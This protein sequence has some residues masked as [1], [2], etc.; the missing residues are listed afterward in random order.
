MP[1]RSAFRNLSRPALLLFLSVYSLMVSAG[2]R[3]PGK[4]S[5]VVIFDRW[6]TCFLLSGPYITYV[7]NEVKEGLRAYRNQAIQI[8]ASDVMQP[9]NP[10][11]ALIRK[12]RIIGPALE[13]S[14]EPAVE[15]IHISIENDFDRDH[16]TAFLITIENL[17]NVPVQIDSTTIGPALLGPKD[18]SPFNPSDGKSMAWITRCD[19]SASPNWSRT[20][21]VNHRTVSAGYS[22]DPNDNE[23]IRFTL[24]PGES[25][26]IHIN[27]HLPSGRY[28]FLVGYGGGVAVGK[29]LASNAISFQVDSDGSAVLD[30]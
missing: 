17:S 30:K 1:R 22:I 19:L 2:T 23:S 5:G 10:G 29:S 24:N 18:D 7:S 28:Q 20:I 12:Y 9:I 25:K 11:D 4:Y 27:F 26:Q 6:D 21:T 16:A 8:D 14:R 3:G 13:D 15:G